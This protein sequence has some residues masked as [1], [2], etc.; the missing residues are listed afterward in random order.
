MVHR[1]VDRYPV[2]ECAG[3]GGGDKHYGPL[4]MF[5]VCKS[6]GPLLGVC[7]YQGSESAGGGGENQHYGALGMSLCVR[8]W[9]T[10]GFTVIWGQ[11]VQAAA[12]GST[13]WT[14]RYVL[15]V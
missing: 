13:L 8:A 3:G 10:V 5:S 11:S 9:C 12:V 2:S 7:H 6:I 1:W 14:S 15:C 4:G